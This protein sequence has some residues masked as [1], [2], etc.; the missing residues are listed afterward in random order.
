MKQ[1][2]DTLRQTLPLPTYGADEQQRNENIAIYI[3]LDCLSDVFLTWL[4]ILALVEEDL[5]ID[6]DK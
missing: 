5:T 2:A 4:P 6:G 1:M 3:V